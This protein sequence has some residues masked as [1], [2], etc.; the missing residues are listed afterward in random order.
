MIYADI[1]QGS[2]QNGLKMVF[3]KRY[4]F[5][6]ESF[7]NHMFQREDLKWIRH[8]YILCLQF[9]WDHEFFDAQRGGY[10]VMDLL[11][12]GERLFGGW[13]VIGLWP[14]WPTLGVDQ[15]NQWDLYKDLPGGLEQI[16]QMAVSMQD[17]GVRFFGIVTKS[18]S[19][20]REMYISELFYE[21]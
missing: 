7:D 3:Q 11:D 5:D 15:R 8:K 19:Q 12:M 6:L 20:S 17:R 2:W 1:F 4:L 10:R 9:A 13:D 18:L 21:S 14:T 16:R